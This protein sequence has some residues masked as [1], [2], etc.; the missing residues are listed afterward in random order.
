MLTSKNS[1]RT[2]IECKKGAYNIGYQ[3]KILILGSCFSENIGKKFL[4]NKFNVL[5]NPFGII[6]NPISICNSLNIIIDKKEFNVKDLFYHNEQWHSFFHHSK[7]S[8]ISEKKVLENIND[9]INEANNL[10]K[11]VSYLIITFGSSYVY[12]HNELNFIVSNCHK[13]PNKTFEQK[14]LSITEMET[15]WI[16]LINKIKI[17]NKNIK[18][19]FTVSP[20]RYLKYGF[21]SNSLSKANLLVLVNNLKNKFDFI[22][23][24]P[25]YEIMMDDLRDYR[26]YDKDMIHPNEIA[27]E[28]IWDKFLDKYLDKD[29]LNIITKIE[30]LKKSILHKPRNPNSTEYKNFILNNM[31][32]LEGLKKEFSLI[33]F[34][35]EFSILKNILEKLN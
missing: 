27:I 16:E 13:I 29:S 12:I 26:F 7:F 10:I 18:I 20:I 28:Y 4:E 8:D 34:E 5:V 9:K 21:S 32:I 31:T 30:K 11:D 19:I 22:D 17:I 1:F 35:D 25:S 2:E 3:D 23:Y 24:F 15:Y 14:M 33:N 6:Y